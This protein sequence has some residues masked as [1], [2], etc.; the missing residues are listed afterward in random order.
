MVFLLIWSSCLLFTQTA[1]RKD[2]LYDKYTLQDN[3]KYNNKSRSFQWDKIRVYL[4]KVDSLNDTYN[5]Y[6]VLDNY[7]NKNGLAPIVEDAPKDKWGSYTDS[8]GVERNQA[9]P[10]YTD[11]LDSFPHRYARDGSLVVLKQEGDYRSLYYVAAIDSM[12]WIDSKY[13]KN[14]GEGSFDKVVFVDVKN[15]NAT[16]ME[17]GDSVWL[18]RSMNPVTTGAEKPPYK[19]STPEGIYVVVGKTMKMLFLV[20]GSTDI[21]GYAPFA[22]RFSGGAYLHGVPVNYPNETMKDYSWTLGTVPRSHRCVRNVTSHAKY[23]YN[24]AEIH[25]TL[26]VI[27]S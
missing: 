23:I 9:I 15:Q 11:S 17:K 21:G 1:I 5:Y 8:Y 16:T 25:R 7:K 19:R 20:D 12:Y 26:V 27:Y 6:S 2:L 3:Y 14:I 24:W 10:L 18:V 13:I 4:S 22:T